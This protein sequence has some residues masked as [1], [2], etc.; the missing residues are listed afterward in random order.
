M[1]VEQSNL[2][3]ALNHLFYKT[4][5]KYLLFIL[6]YGQNTPPYTFVYFQSL[7]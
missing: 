6:E 3:G 1:K 7:I 5:L 4:Y 2:F